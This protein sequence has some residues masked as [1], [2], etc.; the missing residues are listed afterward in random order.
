MDY[1][2]A[3]LIRELVN[4]FGEDNRRIEHAL[5]VLHH[6][7]N[8]IE[9]QVECDHE[10]VIAAALLHDIGIKVSEEKLGYNN[11]KTQELYGPSEAEK[12]LRSVAFPESKIEAVKKIIGSHHTS[13]SDSLPELSILMQADRIVNS[14][15]KI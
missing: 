1:P 11:G 12:I 13:I 7:D 4:Y 8:I 10:I 5:R 9:Q 2:R 15:E 14:D 6:A 3:I